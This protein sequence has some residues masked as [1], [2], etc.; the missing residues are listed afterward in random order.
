MWLAARIRRLISE[1]K[2]V[3]LEANEHEKLGD[4]LDSV[5]GIKDD[6]IIKKRSIHMFTNCM[7]KTFG[8]H[9]SICT[10]FFQLWFL[11]GGK[12]VT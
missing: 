6:D 2:N 10:F 8:L 11:S 4:W 5:L 7:F 1:S 12:K 9:A 3:A